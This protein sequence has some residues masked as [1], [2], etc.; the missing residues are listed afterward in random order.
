MGE[1]HI[2][3]ELREWMDQDQVEIATSAREAM[4]KLLR[5]RN[6]TMMSGI[7]AHPAVKLVAG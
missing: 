1:R 6:D 7:V 2:N 4:S 5:T 3:T